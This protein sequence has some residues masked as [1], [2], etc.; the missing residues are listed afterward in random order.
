MK[1]KKQVF[2]TGATGNMGSQTLK[3]LLKRKDHFMIKALV[4]DTPK[5]NTKLLDIGQSF[6]GFHLLLSLL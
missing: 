2:L 6:H 5:E 3:E 4:L 1:G